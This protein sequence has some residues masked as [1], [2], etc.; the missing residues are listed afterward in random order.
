MS[1][2]QITRLVRQKDGKEREET[3]VTQQPAAHGGEAVELPRAPREFER[4][5][6]AAF[7][8]DEAAEKRQKTQAVSREDL[9]ARL[10]A[11]E[12]RLTALE[13]SKGDVK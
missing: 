2:Y 11:I 8:K 12:E 10:A 5:D 13:P 1:H 7:V 4:F 9:V 3:I 6:G